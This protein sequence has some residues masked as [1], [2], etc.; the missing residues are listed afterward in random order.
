M[1][2]KDNTVSSFDAKTHLSQLLQEVEKGQ[3][4]TI[5]RRGKPVAC[6]VPV[7]E[8]S[9]ASVE[10]IVEEL[11]SVRRRIKGVFDVKELIREGRKH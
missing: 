1:K 9:E 8:E 11:A 4:I 7:R 10:H 3:S 2:V 5:T 6:L